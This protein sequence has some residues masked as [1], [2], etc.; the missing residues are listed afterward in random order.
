MFHLIVTKM[1]G[2]DGIKHTV[3]EVFSLVITTELPCSAIFYF[4]VSN[5]DK[6]AV[7]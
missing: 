2:L 6:E 1:V 5:K 4:I 7:E 3:D